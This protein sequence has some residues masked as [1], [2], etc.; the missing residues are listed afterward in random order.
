MDIY[1][2]NQIH[3]IFN[4]QSLIDLGEIIYYFTLNLELGLTQ[5]FCFGVKRDHFIVFMTNDQK[6]VIVS[7]LNEVT[8]FQKRLILECD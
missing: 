2:S 7:K 5:N 4:L 3:L 6:L 8:L 1:I